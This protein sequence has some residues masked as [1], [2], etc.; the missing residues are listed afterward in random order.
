MTQSELISP[1][2]ENDAEDAQRVFSEFY[3]QYQPVFSKVEVYLGQIIREAPEYA[4]AYRPWHNA[5]H[6]LTAGISSITRDHKLPEDEEF[7]EA[8]RMFG[9]SGA[10]HFLEDMSDN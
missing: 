2:G 8:M 10:I 4:N 3:S 7:I 9:F 6:N 5:L 1:P